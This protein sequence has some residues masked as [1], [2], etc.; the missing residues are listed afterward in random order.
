MIDK[1]FCGMCEAPRG[2]RTTLTG[3]GARYNTNHRAPRY[4]PPEMGALI[5]TTEEMFFDNPSGES[6]FRRLR[7]DLG[8]Y[9]DFG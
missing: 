5:G 3:G 4:L 6:D 2:P 7:H 8:R 9:S 1:R